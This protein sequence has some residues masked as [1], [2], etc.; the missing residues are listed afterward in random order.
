MPDFFFISYSSVDGKDFAL[1]LANELQAGPPEIGVWL[2]ER[3]LRPA[4]DWDEQIAEAIKKCKGMIFVMTLDSVSANSV[5][6]NE[7]VRALRYKKPIIPVLL[8]PDAELPLRL[9]SREYIDFS[10]SFGSAVARLRKHLAWMDSPEGHLQALKYRRADAQ[11][12]LPRARP[13][14]HVRIREDIAELERQITHQQKVIE[15][16]KAAEQRV[17]QSI[18]VGLE[19]ERQPVMPVGGITIG[20][21]IYPPP[22]IAPTWF[23]DRHSE[24]RQI[25]DFLKDESLRLITVVGRGGIGKTAMVCRLLRSLEGG[26]LPDGGGPLT[27]DGIVY[28]NAARSLHR[29]S[30][31]D[32]YVGLTNLLPEETVKQLDSVYKNPQAT[33][34]AIMEALVESFP[35]G[36]TVVLLDNFEDVLTIETGQIKD[37]ELNDALRALLELPP[38]G[39]KIIITTRIA[40][41]DLP[42][43]QPGLQRRLN[44]D[45]GLEYPYAENI[46]R[47]MDV[48]G[49][50]GLRDAPVILLARARERTRGYPRALE[51][52]FGI[53]SADRDT[54]LG[55]ILDNTR[56]VLPE[57]VVTVL[58]GEAYSR[59]DPNAQRVMQAL[60]IFRYPVP[61]AAV[62]YLLQPYVHGIDSSRVL[63][64][65]VNM[66]FVSRDAGRYYLHQVDRE[67]ALSRIEEG[68]PGDRNAEPPV[69]TRFALKHRAADWFKLSR[70]PRE[71]WKVLGDLAAQLSEFELRCEGNDYDTAAALLL[72]FDFDYLFLWGHYR[73]MSELHERLQGRITDPELAENSAG[74]LGTAYGKLGNIQKAIELCEEA[75]RSARKR[76]DR[77]GE[78]TWLGN[79]ANRLGDLGQNARAIEYLEQTLAISREVRDRKSESADLGNLGNRH[80]EIGQIDQAIQ[81]FE[82]A[83]LIER[84]IGTL[85]GE[86]G[87]LVNLGERYKELGRTDEALRYYIKGLSAAREIGYRL[88]EALGHENVARLYVSQKNWIDAA[89][90]FEEAIEIADEIGRPQRSR[91]AR[92]GFALVNIYRN[93]LTSARQLVEAARKYDVT[94]GNH[95]SSAMLGIVALLQGD[96]NI[97]REAFTA[98]INQA[99]Q[100]I[101]LTPERYEAL[102]VKGLSLCG[103]V[104]CGDRAQVPAAKAAYATARRVT[105]AP[106]ITR[107]VLLYFDA[108]AQADKEGILAEVRPFAAGKIG[109]AQT[110]QQ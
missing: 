84:E 105:S 21:F 7:W 10:R 59:L 54:S 43:V 56:N 74:N 108:L 64:R 53:L 82:Q 30:L 48:D 103:L 35:R 66:Q 68:V 42:L 62:D 8:D 9:G 77:W 29:V 81:Y 38:H 79:L 52:F 109:L 99:D 22:L 27:V 97:A 75:L 17:Q 96:L 15:N 50:V 16:P 49:K 39:I 23:E 41:A 60:A 69:L 63:S 14:Q 55:E 24:T 104:L 65:L 11:R 57:Q 2:D 76:N 19:G 25:G 72:E 80:A 45:T 83:L 95:S 73:L 86:A 89:R 88:F 101:I 93:N 94:L 44:L 32:L 85:G 98:A 107:D 36:R 91:D 33:T 28:L 6:K 3:D 70:K 92:E 46:L 102:D 87:I 47:A 51:H 67:Y 106:G 37:A 34:R 5:C 12:E 18:E 90:E 20:K 110:P 31:P 100:L 78:G 40:P 26:Q 13:E 1:K 58:V 4:E 71:A 61:P